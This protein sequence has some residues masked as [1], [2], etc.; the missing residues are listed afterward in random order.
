MRSVT[1]ALAGFTI[2][3][4]AAR[5]ERLPVHRYSTAD[6]L[7]SNWIGKISQDS[8]GYLW[9]VTREGLSR[10]D[11]YDFV[12]YTTANGLPRNTITDFLEAR[13]GVYWV[14]TTAGL[15]RFDPQTAGVKKFTPYAPGEPYNPRINA[16][17]QD[18]KEQL[19]CGTNDGLFRLRQQDPA[20][21]VW[22]FE[23]VELTARKGQVPDHRVTSIFE[24]SR[25]DLWVSAIRSLYRLTRNGGVHEYQQGLGIDELWSGVLEDHHG[26]LWASNGSGLWELA[27]DGKGD[28]RLNA[29]LKPKDRLIIFDML[30]DEGGTLWLGTNSGLIACAGANDCKAHGRVYAESNGLT[31]KDVLSLCVDRAGNLWL[32]T[33][34]SGAMRIA[35]SGFVTYTGADGLSFETQRHPTLFRDRSGEVHVAFSSLLYS[36]KGERF[37]PVLPAIPGTV[38]FPGWGWHQVVLQDHE[39]EWWIATGDGLV[40]FSAVPLDDLSHTPAKA[41]YTTRN[42]LRTQEIFRVFE[43]SRG[44]V[45]VACIGPQGVNGLT[46]WCRRENAFQ[47]QPIHDSTTASAFAEDRDGA[48]WVGYYDGAL[49][50]FHNGKATLYGPADGLPKGGI[51]ALHVDHAGR[52]WIAS[53]GGGVSRLDHPGEPHP[54]FARY[55]LE[56][57]LS[58]NLI[59][60]MDEDSRGEIY[61]ATGR[62]LDRID[63]SGEVKPG[64]IRHYSEADGLAPGEFRDV[65]FDHHGVLW[66]ATTQGISHFHPEPEASRQRAPVLIRQVRV[67][68]VPQ[69]FSDLGLSTVPLLTLAPGQNQVQIDFSSMSFA[70]GEVLRYQYRLDPTDAEWSE[71]TAQRTVNYST[72]PPGRYHFS[73]RLATVPSGAPQSAATL[74]FEVL[75]PFWQRWW[76]RV[77]AFCA[78]LGLLV[79]IHHYRTARLLELERI[80]TRIATDL[81]DDI[82]SGLAQIAV[83][84][85][86]S[87]ARTQSYAADLNAALGNIGSVSR[88]MAESLNDI[89]WSV[90]PQRDHATDLLQRIRRFASDV[91]SGS[92]ISFGFRSSIPD[93]ALLPTELRREVYLIFKE[94]INNLVRHSGSTRA[95]ISIRI[96]NDWLELVVED[97]GNGLNEAR[98][99]QGHGLR[100][101]SERA[102]RIGGSIEFGPGPDGGLKLTLTAPVG[103]G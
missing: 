35:R 83:L 4:T 40:R 47:P 31:Y 37:I 87:R 8:R 81:H 77:P 102:R 62:G 98:N 88:E 74:E 79:W 42:G 91:L 58:S 51:Q 57:G 63:A 11:G 25:G 90:N 71:P 61:L 78:A 96:A 97:N 46:R 29:V 5:G 66:C 27:P 50:R 3:L 7:P 26:R 95:E 93:G 9:F 18:H 22:R 23:P 80:R 38:R 56:Q 2:A 76:F 65:L 48:V 28:Y 68:G 52:L 70:P 92:G 15:A 21:R 33:E 6:G 41:V 82:G 94:A 99:W 19:W 45:W 89:V 55:G 60:C 85:E 1:V 59:F 32:G 49:V 103:H 86:A 67:R 10:Y 39:G 43:D 101:M 36:R 73:A 54:H 30:M 64:T 14:A 75:A 16:I 17:Y 24:D 53:M 13:D 84:A 69:A 44:D 72:V 12:N 34:G 20:G 100:S